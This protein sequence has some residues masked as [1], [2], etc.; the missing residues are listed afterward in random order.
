MPPSSPQRALRALWCVSRQNPGS[1]CLSPPSEAAVRL[2]S[3]A[4]R[5]LRLRDASPAT[6]TNS[7]SIAGRELA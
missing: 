6:L 1:R 2:R 7:D 5:A 3:L 4:A